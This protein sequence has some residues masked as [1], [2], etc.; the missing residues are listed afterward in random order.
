M[1]L[2]KANDDLVRRVNELTSK[3]AEQEEA[4]K[5]VS[6]Y[7]S[8]PQTTSSQYFVYFQSIL[9]NFYCGTWPDEK[10]KKIKKIFK[11]K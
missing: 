4:C 9:I 7:H 10:E 6:K 5:S 1:I 8:V 11:K 2:K 3:K